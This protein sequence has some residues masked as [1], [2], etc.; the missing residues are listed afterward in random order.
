MNAR[1]GPAFPSSPQLRGEASRGIFTRFTKF[2]RTGPSVSRLCLGTGTF[3]KQTEEAESI[4][5]FEHPD[6]RR[7]DDQVEAAVGRR[8]HL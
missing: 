1:Y 2:S 5:V 6:E 7:R 3:G 4:R 8:L